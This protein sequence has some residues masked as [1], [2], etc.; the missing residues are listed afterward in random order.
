MASRLYSAFVP[1]LRETKPELLLPHLLGLGVAGRDCGSVEEAILHSS[2]R[3]KAV[4]L[5]HVD[6]RDGASE[7]RSLPRSFVTCQK[8]EIH[9]W[10]L[11]IGCCSIGNP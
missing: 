2:E 9:R 1:L 11:L 7:D 4:A 8:V 6:V 5:L 10:L 3:D